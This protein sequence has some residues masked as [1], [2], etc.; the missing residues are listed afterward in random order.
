MSS[1]SSDSDSEIIEYI[2]RRRRT[3]IR[4][5]Q[6]LI[7]DSDFLCRYRISKTMAHYICRCIE[8]E[9]RSNTPRSVSNLQLSTRSRIYFTTK[10]IPNCY[11][12]RHFNTIIPTG[13]VFSLYLL[14]IKLPLPTYWLFYFFRNNALSVSDQLLIALRF[15]STCSMQQVVGD[16]S[17]VHKASVCRAIHRVSR[18]IAALAPRYVY[19]PRDTDEI[20]VV[21]NDFY[22]IANF[23]RV[24]GAIDCTHIPI[25]SPG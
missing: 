16:I 22:R 3:N 5:D 14:F 11:S 17:R 24:I 15:Y 25:Q 8:H 20:S 21:T 4:V 10:R 2:S 18:A 12:S 1:T 6:M 19:M 7:E 23:P 13:T 9:V